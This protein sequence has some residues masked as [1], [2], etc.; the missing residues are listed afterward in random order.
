MWAMLK[1]LSLYKSKLI[2]GGLTG[3]LYL[4]PLPKGIDEQVI[5]HEM[6][7]AIVRYGTGL[8]FFVVVE[9]VLRR[10]FKRKIALRKVLR[11]YWRKIVFGRAARLRFSGKKK[12]DK[13]DDERSI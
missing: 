2:A 13:K 7:L 9:F 4:A 3:L 11:K 10:F 1:I 5:A 6:I 8:V 12:T